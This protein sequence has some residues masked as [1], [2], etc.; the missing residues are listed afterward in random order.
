MTQPR[1]RYVLSTALELEAV[2][3]PV[4]HHVLRA[5]SMLGTCSVKELAQ[6][7]GRS[8]ESL[9]YHLR[10][11][12][13]A[14]LVIER[15]ER[16]VQG[17]SEALYATIAQRLVTD[18]KQ[19]SPDYIDA[20]KDSAAALLRLADRQVGTALE[21]QKESGSTRPIS[22]RIQQVQARLSPK[23]QRELARRLDDVLQFLY[24]AD[25]AEQPDR[26]VVTLVSAP[27]GPAPYSTGHAVP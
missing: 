2:V 16:V 22:L 3:S 25:D 6:Q 18:P 15:G 11:L 8:P 5:L 17:R 12:Q 27:L 9:Y 23:S 13:D 24:E 19:T 21:H 1:K 14:G 10:A 20:F 26:V 4:R 7:L